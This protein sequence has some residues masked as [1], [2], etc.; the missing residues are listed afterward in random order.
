MVWNALLG[1]SFFTSSNQT[2]QQSD[3][4]VNLIRHGIAWSNCSNDQL[5]F[6]TLVR[7]NKMYQNNF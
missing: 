5:A 1:R 4:F 6:D 3:I 7:T 2:F